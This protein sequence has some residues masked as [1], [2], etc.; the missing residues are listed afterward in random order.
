MAKWLYDKAVNA[1]WRG[2]I[3]L[4]SAD[5]RVQVVDIDYTPSQASDEFFSSVAAGA[6]V[7]GGFSAAGLASKTL[8]GRVFDAADLTLPLVG[9]GDDPVAIVLLVW[10]GVDATSRLLAYNNE[11]IAIRDPNGAQVVLVWDSGVNK[12]VSL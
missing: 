6:R 10:T 3:D 4:T 12:I 7:S 8:T 9:G 5:I 1:A 11:V 2:L